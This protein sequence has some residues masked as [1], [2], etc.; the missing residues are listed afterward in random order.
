MPTWLRSAA[1]C[2]GPSPPN[3]LTA[4]VERCVSLIVIAIGGHL[5]LQHS[6]FGRALRAIGSNERAAEVAGFSVAGMK[7][8]AFIVTGV[9]AGTA[10]IFLTGMLSTANGIM[11]TG[12]ELSAITIVVVG[13]TSLRGGQASMLG[14]FVAALFVGLMANAMNLMRIDSYWQYFATGLIL[15]AA[16]LLGKLRT[17]SRIRGE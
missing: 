4:R 1:A 12:L 2:Y 8:V 13:G 10:A 6:Y 9:L 7:T 17:A 3:A 5:L 11:A 14:T 16:L 15:I